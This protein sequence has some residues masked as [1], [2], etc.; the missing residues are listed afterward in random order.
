[1]LI[2]QK[3]RATVDEQNVKLRGG[4]ENGSRPG[5]WNG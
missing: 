4:A 5:R 3:R 1:M 2:L